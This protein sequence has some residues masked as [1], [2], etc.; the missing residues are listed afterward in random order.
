MKT[1]G[2]ILALIAADSPRLH[3]FHVLREIGPEDAWAD[4]DF[5]RDTIWDHLYGHGEAM[6]LANVNVL[7]FVPWALNPQAGIDSEVVLRRHCEVSWSVKNQMH[8]RLRDDNRPYRDCVDALCHQAETRT[9]VALRLVGERLEL[10][11]PLGVD[12]LLTLGA[13]STAHLVGKSGVYR[14]RL[15]EKNWTAR[16]LLLDTSGSNQTPDP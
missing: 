2:D 12:D 7:H 4:T 8:M 10:P 14:R 6:P 13:R 11:V 9:A 5:V 1:T 3:L 15:R 16:W